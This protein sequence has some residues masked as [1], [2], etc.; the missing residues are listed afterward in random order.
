M[1]NT[2]KQTDYKKDF[3]KILNDMDRSKS[4]AENFRNFC[5]M[6][7]CAL[8]KK[9]ATDEETANAFEERYMSI[10]ST[11]SD[12]DDVRKMPEMLCFITLALNEKGCDFLG[13]IAADIE[14]LDKKRGQFF[15]PYDVS[16]LMAYITIPSVETIIKEEG[17]FSLSDP[18]AGSGCMILVAADVVQE[19]GYNPMDYMSVQAVEINKLTYYM[20]FI[21][22]S[23]RGIAAE[24]IH[25][26]SLSLEV[27]E[28][29]YTPAALHF[30]G[31]HGRMF[32]ENNGE[33]SLLKP[34]LKIAPILNIEQLDLF[35]F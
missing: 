10:V 3:I 19:Q 27:F 21:Q 9:T 16:K 15:T 2:N 33:N 7:Y 29:A 28:S 1:P 24:V 25:G 30:F 13:E 34:D 23:M 20:L 18:A 32:K 5:E 31:K 22:L 4:R 11:Y 8:A 35:K 26:N 12:K 6:S 17:F 14:V